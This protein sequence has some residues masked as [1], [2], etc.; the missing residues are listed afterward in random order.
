MIKKLSTSSINRGAL[1]L[2]FS[3]SFGGEFPQQYEISVIFPRKFLLG[4]FQVRRIAMFY[5][6]SCPPQKN[7]CILCFCI[8]GTL[9]PYETFANQQ[10]LHQGLGD[11]LAVPNKF[12]AYFRDALHRFQRCFWQISWIFQGNFR[13]VMLRFQG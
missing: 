13:D 1:S 12:Q 2:I 8:P 6:D 9:D 3:W 7:L 4:I 11:L 5:G 10:G